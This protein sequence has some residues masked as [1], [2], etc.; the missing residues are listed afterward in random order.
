MQC[1]VRGCSSS[2]DQFLR[3]EL[4]H[5]SGLAKRFFS[6]ARGVF[7]SAS[8][9]DFC[10]LRKNDFKAK[11]AQARLEIVDRSQKKLPPAGER[12]ILSAASRALMRLGQRRG[13]V[14]LDLSLR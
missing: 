5:V 11:R 4:P 8:S 3:F 9:V 14:R 6:I 10:F 2:S 7:L 13:H 12:S 1:Q